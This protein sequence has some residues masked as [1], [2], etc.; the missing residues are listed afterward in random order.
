MNDIVE[1]ARK[2]INKSYKEQQVKES[3]DKEDSN[4]VHTSFLETKDYIL[5]QI[6]PT[7]L[8]EHTEGSG[9]RTYLQYTKGLSVGEDLE[10]IKLVNFIEYKNK[11]YYP[12]EGEMMDMGIIKLSTGVEEY[13]TTEKLIKEIQEFFDK[14]FEAPDF[15]QRFLPYM[16]LF[17]WVYD[18]FPFIPYLHFMGRTGTGKSTAMEVVGN[19][20][21]KTIDVSGSITMSSIFRIATEWKGTLMLDEFLPN[22]DAYAEMLSLLKSGVSDRAVL[23]VEGEKQRKVTPYLIKSPKLFTSEKPVL[24]AGLRSRVIEVRMNKN[25]KRLPLYR[26]GNFGNEAVSLRN[27]LLL[28]RLRNLNKINLDN[29]LYGFKELQGFD[30]RVQQVITP[31]YYMA[32]TE[33]RK[34]IEEFA[35]QQQQE[36]MKE[37]LESLHGQVFEVILGFFD[38]ALT[39]SLSQIAEKINPNLKYDLTEK[40]LGIIVRKELGYEIRRAGLSG[41]S[42]VFENEE[43]T[44]ELK[45]YYGLVEKNMVVSPERSEPSVSSVDVQYNEGKNIF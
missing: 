34:E 11:E 3:K 45:E 31:I 25:R 42:I 43:L 9:G 12:I 1:K 32:D 18:K 38:Q 36:T 26:T 5:E 24:D 29:I 23:R 13:E 8:T 21:Y 7:E 16:V 28:W 33:A 17:Y 2:K 22:G 10:A 41:N 4:V 39:P 15:F 27:K 40:K 30:G 6:N 37:R 20:C 19:I 44:A 35:K 14:Y